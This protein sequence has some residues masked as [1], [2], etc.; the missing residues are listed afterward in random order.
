MLNKGGQVTIFI[1]VAIIIV[2]SIGAYFVFRDSISTQP[3]PSSLEPVYTAFLTC[4][5]DKALTGI[6]ILE[7]QGGYIELPEFEPGSRYMP[8]SSQLDFLGNPIPYWYYVSGNNIQKEQVPSKGFMQNQLGEFV[9]SRSQACD[10]SGYYEQ[11]F[12]I[13]FQDEGSG[14]VV[15]KEDEV[16]LD[17]SIDLVITK[18]EDTVLIKDHKVVVSSN[19]GKLYDNAKEVY[20][21]EQTTLFL[22]NYAVDNLRNYAPVDGVEISCSPQVWN[23]EEVFDELEEGIEVN[24]LALRARTNDFKLVNKE[25]E[26]FIVDLPVDSDV[27]VKF[28]NSRNW[29]NGFEVNPSQ[30]P[31]MIS[32]PVGNQQGLGILGFCYVPYHYVYNL[33]YPVLIQVSSG[34]GFEDEVF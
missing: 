8:F 13:S 16:E 18:N 2:A 24:T 28:L 26:Y 9:A 30:G 19:L 11:G 5:E 22:E 14:K 20:D 1:I 33:R 3:I 21:Y 31:V 17:L 15:I 34:S 27:E 7:S 4:V 12:E 10:F 29:A 25:N 32:E 23:A 6:D